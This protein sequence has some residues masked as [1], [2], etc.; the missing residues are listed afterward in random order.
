MK[1]KQNAKFV[2]KDISALRKA[3]LVTLVVL[4][5][6]NANLKQNAHFVLQNIL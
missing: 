6:M 3:L 2:I 5:A 4:I 1:K